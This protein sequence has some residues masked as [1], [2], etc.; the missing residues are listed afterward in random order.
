MSD[1]RIINTRKRVLIVVIASLI[2]FAVAGIVNTYAVTMPTASG[3]VK[4]DGG[5][6]L[7]KKASTSS[8]KVKLLKNK[9]GVIIEKEVFVSKKSTSAKKKW[10]LVKS[11]KYE[12]YIRSD[13][14]SKIDYYNVTA[15]T[16]TELNYRLGPATSMTK[17]GSF[18][19]G[20]N[21][22][23]VLPAKVQG[24]SETWYK[25]KSG[26]KYYYISS[27]YV[28]F[29]DKVNEIA[30]E[31][32][33]SK[34]S[35]KSNTSAV[36]WS[37]AGV[38]Y[39]V[40]I[41]QGSSFA[42]K[43][44]LGS[45]KTIEKAEVGVVDSSGKWV[46]KSEAKVGSKSFN[47]ASVDKNVKFGMLGRG[48]YTY[49]VVLYVGGKGYTRLAYKFSVVQVSGPSL[50]AN[51]AITL[52]WPVGTSKSK[53]SYSSGVATPEYKKALDSVFPDRDNWSKLPKNGASCD[54]F[55][56][57]VCRYSGYDVAMPRGLDGQW[58]AFED[59]SKWSRVNYNF[60]ETD[61]QSG[62]IFIYKKTNG[63]SHVC[64]YV[65]IDGKGYIAEASYTNKYYGYINTSLSKILKSSD[66]TSIKVYRACK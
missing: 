15:K 39:P 3:Q 62:D 17:V 59:T 55:I 12:G 6:Y 58:K 22:T 27:K 56:S 16:R 14:V 30:V 42:L 41:G 66:K 2:I 54:V 44:V 31:P 43:G 51:T 23:V 48:K 35:S 11:G 40:S 37:S 36:V 57:T 52:A 28:Q 25:I 21:T 1:N 9:T 18:P 53:Y 20:T 5:A 4:A 46:I 19:K 47:I 49:K 8:S 7:R 26:K 65:V 32:T 10:Y 38:T 50:L 29:V 61:L 60:K 45:N 13:L 33:T 64:M 34:V 24:I 63:N